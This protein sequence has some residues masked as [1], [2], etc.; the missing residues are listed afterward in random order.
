MIKF[1]V[2]A[3]RLLAFSTKSKIFVTADS[4]SSFA[5]Q[6]QECRF[7]SQIQQALLFLLPHLLEQTHQL[8]QRYPQENNRLSRVHPKEFFTW[9]DDNTVTRFNFFRLYLFVS[10]PTLRFAYSGRIFINSLID[11]LE[12]FTAAPWNSSPIW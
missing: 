4:L 1:S 12:R 5:L 2:C 6:F 7:G 3:L 9:F 10:C 8:V 11:F